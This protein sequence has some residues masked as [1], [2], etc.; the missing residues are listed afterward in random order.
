METIG[1]TKELT[2]TRTFNAPR[3]LVWKAWTEQKHIEKW[4]GPKGF[5]NPVCEW[6]ATTGGKINIH[7]KGPDGN[8]YPMGGK[9]STITKPEKIVFTSV[10]LGENDKH[11]FDV[12]NTITFTDEGDKTK[13]TLHFIFSNIIP[14]AEKNI[15]GASMGW[16]MSLDKLVELLKT[17]K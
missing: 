17:L 9:F 8:I 12:L 14:E 13:L 2:I 16:N 4:W 5:T 11:L 6:D 15:A 1:K 7:M 10:A 3:E